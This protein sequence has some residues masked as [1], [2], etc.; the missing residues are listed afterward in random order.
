MTTEPIKNVLIIAGP[1][2]MASDKNDIELLRKQ[3]EDKGAKVFLVG[4][5][6]RDISIDEIIAEVKNING[7][8]TVF[9]SAHGENKDGHHSTFLSDAPTRTSEIFTKI[10]EVSP[11]RKDY[12]LIQCYGGSA[13][14]DCKD[15]IKYGS[16][17]VTLTTGSETNTSAYIKDFY[18]T[19]S[20]SKVL[21]NDFSAFSMLQ[22]YLT[23]DMQGRFVPSIANS[24]G[25]SLN[26]DT[27]MKSLLGNKFSEEQLKIIH[28]N[29]DNTLGVDRVNEVINKMENAKN[30]WSIYAVDY[31]E[32]CTVALL[33]AKE[34]FNYSFEK[35]EQNLKC[36]L[37]GHYLK[38]N[39]KFDKDLNDVVK[40]L[41]GTDYSIETKKE[42]LVRELNDLKPKLGD[43]F[44]F[45][46]Q[47]KYL[48]K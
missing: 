43:A 15:I 23:T 27:E 40:I 45:G 30:E 1:G 31:G 18:R 39:L 10:E 8:F 35:L 42:D 25:M 38:N 13:I 6:E 14:Q 41:S 3:L 34:K 2:G 47:E 33:L 44:V 5:G 24:N 37:E 22:D 7:D 21:G 4:D 20:E 12:F 48:A 11:Y 36:D 32:A 19:L 29:M 16:N 17:I 28:N 46:L 9:F 26:L